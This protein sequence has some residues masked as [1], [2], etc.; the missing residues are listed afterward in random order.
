VTDGLVLLLMAVLLIT[1]VRSFL[2]DH[3]DDDEWFERN[4][5][6][7]EEPPAAARPPETRKPGDPADREQ[8]SSRCS[9]LSLTRTSA[10]DHDHTTGRVRGLLCAG[11]N[12]AL[13]LLGDDAARVRQLLEYLETT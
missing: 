9:R 12:R 3:I 10:V 4:T 1:F 5:W 2:S 13:G 11:C 6:P 8:F 7:T